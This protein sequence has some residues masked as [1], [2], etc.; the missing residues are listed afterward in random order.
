M[1]YAE[2]RPSCLRSI[3]F[4]AAA[5]V[6]AATTVRIQKFWTEKKQKHMLLL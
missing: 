4:V 2:K 1:K 3:V 6:S 5:V